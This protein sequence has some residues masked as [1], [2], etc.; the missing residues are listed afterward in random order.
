MFISFILLYCTLNVFS[1][2]WNWVLSLSDFPFV[3]YYKILDSQTWWHFNKFMC[4]YSKTI[5]VKYKSSNLN[6]LNDSFIIV[7]GVSL[8][9]TTSKLNWG[10][11]HPSH[12]WYQ[13]LFCLGKVAKVWICPLTSTFC[14]VFE[15]VE[16]V[17][18][19]L[20]LRK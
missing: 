16:Y 14:Q 3:K 2:I 5:T 12:Q 1:W 17:A 10:P 8:S 19:F 7:T 6:W 20:F 11:A 15:C 13:R 4:I 9:V 18:V